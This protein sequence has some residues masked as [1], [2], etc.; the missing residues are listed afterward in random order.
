M[1]PPTPTPGPRRERPGGFPGDTSQSPQA[2]LTPG[3]HSPPHTSRALPGFELSGRQAW[4][5]P[6][7]L[8]KASRQSPLPQ[9][10]RGGLSVPHLW[11]KHLVCAQVSLTP[12]G[13]FLT[14][15]SPGE[16][17]RA[18]PGPLQPYRPLGCALSPGSSS[19]QPP[20]LHGPLKRPPPPDLPCCVAALGVIAG[21][22]SAW[23]GRKRQWGRCP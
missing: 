13:P 6:T 23:P 16:G 10:L 3:G 12:V 2:L 20:V 14:A 19:T 17:L 5:T 1:T 8:S 22:A 11:L 4:Q 7:H 9:A 18:S 21:T 15:V